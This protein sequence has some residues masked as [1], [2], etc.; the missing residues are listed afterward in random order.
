MDSDQTVKTVLMV[1][2]DRHMYI[3]GSLDLPSQIRVVLKH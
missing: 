3:I 1:K 2:P